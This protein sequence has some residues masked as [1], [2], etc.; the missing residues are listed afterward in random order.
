MPSA[1]P[2]DVRAA[3]AKRAPA[4]VYL[5]LGDDDAE[6]SRLAADIT[7]VVEDELRVFNVERMYGG[8]KATTAASIVEAARML[9]M[10]SDRRVVVVVRA[11]R[12]L[13]PKRRGKQVEESD[14]GEE[15]PSDLDALTAYV[16]DPSPSTTLVLAAAD[17][18]KTRKAGKEILKHAT[19]VECWGLKTEK[20]PRFTD[21]RA[22]ARVA[23]Q[24]VRK[25]V[26]EAGQV[27]EPAAARLLAERAGVDIV[28]L[29][30]D[31]ERLMLYAAGKP[32]ITLADARE[33]VS[34]ES[35]HDDWAVTNA[36]Q[37]GNTKEA[38]R[39]LA[40]ALEAG[41]VSYQI[42]GQLA[43]FVRDKMSDTRRIPAAIEALFRTDLDLKSSGGDPRVLLERLV[44][45]L[46]RR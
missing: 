14:E 41:G 25:A 45:E 37:N 7:S 33:V 26:A 24:L 15:A 35:S 17:I 46:C 11:E 9:P 42:L 1:S 21:F 44:V 12:L 16:R 34:A 32:N 19:V 39:Q 28:R 20:N 40:L 2:A 38:L 29:R 5:L 4:P 43:W 10:M 6:L 22:T 30:G 36:I 23:E 3:I 27:I 8:E 13:K 31:I 18:D